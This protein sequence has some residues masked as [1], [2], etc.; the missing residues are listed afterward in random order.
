MTW[1]STESLLPL[2]N[3]VRATYFPCSRIG[4][5][6]VSW[7][8]TAPRSPVGASKLTP[9]GDLKNHTPQRGVD[10]F[11][12]PFHDKSVTVTRCRRICFGRQKVNLSSVFAG[13][14]VGIKESSDNIW[15]VS[16]MLYDLGYFGHES[17]RLE[18]VDNPFQ[19]RALPIFPYK[20]LPMSPISMD[21]D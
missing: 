6:R 1:A 18:C 19:A 9:T 3:S 10:P 8:P 16:F 2:R 13:Q 14:N 12:Y 21:R 11:D 17:C 4:M 5:T 20:P 15:R 7:I